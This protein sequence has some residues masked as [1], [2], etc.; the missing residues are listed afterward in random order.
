M[1]LRR[2]ELGDPSFV[3]RSVRGLLELHLVSY[4][5]WVGTIEK[6][7]LEASVSDTHPLV[8]DEIEKNKNKIALKVD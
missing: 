1:S 4:S 8:D 5:N 2:A 7:Q 3:Q 6:M